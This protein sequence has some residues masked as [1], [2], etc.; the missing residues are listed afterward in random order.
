MKTRTTFLR[1]S[2]LFAAVCLWGTATLSLADTANLRALTEQI[3]TTLQQNDTQYSSRDLQEI[4]D[5]LR[6]LAA[7]R[8][9]GDRSAMQAEVDVLG[10]HHGQL[11]GLIARHWNLPTRPTKE[12]DTRARAFYDEFGEGTP[13]IELDA[14]AST[15]ILSSHHGH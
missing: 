1:A 6:A 14:D 5:L 7:A 13:S 4:G 9:E 12:T 8:A 3:K 11:G 10:V 2:T 15:V